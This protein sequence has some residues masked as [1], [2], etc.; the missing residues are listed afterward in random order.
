M[1]AADSNKHFMVIG[2]QLSVVSGKQVID[3]LIFPIHQKPMDFPPTAMA[4]ACRMGKARM[5]RSQQSGDGGRACPPNQP[6]L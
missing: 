4:P 3:L 5:M 2:G 1:I 6:W